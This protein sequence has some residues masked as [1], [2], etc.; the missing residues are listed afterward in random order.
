MRDELAVKMNEQL[1]AMEAKHV[2]QMR[3][4]IKEQQQQ[5]PQRQ[6][7]TEAIPPQPDKSRSDKIGVSDSKV[8]NTESVKHADSGHEIS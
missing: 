6:S 7:L 1:L 8:K 5:R 3:K 4:L 2:E